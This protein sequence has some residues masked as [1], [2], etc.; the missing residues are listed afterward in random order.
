MSAIIRGGGRARALVKSV[1]QENLLARPGSRDMESQRRFL[2]TMT[3]S[4]DTSFEQLPCSRDGSTQT[5]PYSSGTTTPTHTRRTLTRSESHH[6]L[7][8][9]P[10]RSFSQMSCQRQFDDQVVAEGARF[11]VRKSRFSPIEGVS[12]FPT[13]AGKMTSDS[14]SMSEVLRPFKEGP[15]QFPLKQ[16]VSMR[17]PPLNRSQSS[18]NTVLAALCAGPVR[19]ASSGRLMQNN[20]DLDL[21]ELVQIWR[22]QLIRSTIPEVTREEAREESPAISPEDTVQ[23]FGKAQDSVQMSSPAPRFKATTSRFPN[24]SNGRWASVTAPRNARLRS[25]GGVIMLRSIVMSSEMDAGMQTPD[26]DMYKHS[27]RYSLTSSSG[28]RT[29]L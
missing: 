7:G 17:A 14:R 15:S 26:E 25:L 29:R 2:K 16:Q 13:A 24:T 11:K 27:R 1:S 8:R 9:T 22:G 28:E 12:R 5:S 19:N 3:I 6:T 18:P 10:S 23:D 21:E 20:H 4:R